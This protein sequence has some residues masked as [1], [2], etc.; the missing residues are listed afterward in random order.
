MRRLAFLQL[1]KNNNCAVPVILITGKSWERSKA[2]YLKHRAVGFFKKPV[3]GEALLDL[4]CS[5]CA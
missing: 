4:I 1:L 3:D 2:F 5:V